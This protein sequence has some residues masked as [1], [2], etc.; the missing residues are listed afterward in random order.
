VDESTAIDVRPDGSW[1]VLGESVVVI[2]DARKSRPA[3]AGRPLGAADIKLHV[4]PA[5]SVVSGDRV[6]L[7]K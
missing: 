7:Q 2:F 6:L 1:L 4:L 5:G 3:G